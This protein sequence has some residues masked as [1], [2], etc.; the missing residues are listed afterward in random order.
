MSLRFT[1]RVRLMRGLRLNFSKSGV[2]LSFGG[3]GAWCTIG[4]R[5]KRAT[6]GLPESGLYWPKMEPWARSASPTPGL[7]CARIGR[8]NSSSRASRPSSWP[9]FSCV[10]IR[11]KMGAGT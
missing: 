8:G 9:R 10:L 1:R 3:R 2:S 6:V 5:G 11:V 7:R 4:P